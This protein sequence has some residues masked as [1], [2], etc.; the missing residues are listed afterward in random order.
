VGVPY[1]VRPFEMLKSES[2]GHYY[3]HLSTIQEWV[4]KLGGQPDQS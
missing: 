3:D 1:D 2:Y 4:K